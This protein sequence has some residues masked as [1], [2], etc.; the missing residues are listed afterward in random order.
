MRLE[1]RRHQPRALGSACEFATPGRVFR[2]SRIA[3]QFRWA[4]P[5]AL[6]R[7][8]EA[9]AFAIDFSPRSGDI[10]YDRTKAADNLTQPPEVDLV[11]GVRACVIVAIAQ[12]RC[13]GGH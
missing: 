10:G 9:S 3:G 4:C 6:L 13:V 2:P 12:R 1:E 8:R 7:S 11:R 5:R